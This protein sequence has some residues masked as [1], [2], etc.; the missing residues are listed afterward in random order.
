MDQQRY[1]EPRTNKRKFAIYIGFFAGF[2]WGGLK[3]IEHYFHFTSL[4]PGFLLEPFFLH[5][6]LS[7]WPGYLLGWVAFTAMSIVAALLYGLLLAKAKG[8]WFGLAYGAAWWAVIYLGVGPLSGMMPWINRMDL[9]TISTDA[10]LF[11][12]WGIFIGYSISFE[13]TDER[14]REPY[15]EKNRSPEPV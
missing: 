12:M 10:C 9:N 14:S 3:M 13:F 1:D 11:L 4:S 7:A 6:F 8:A 15:G 5:S 2:I